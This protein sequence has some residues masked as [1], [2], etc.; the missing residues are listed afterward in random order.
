MWAR[1]ASPITLRDPSPGRRAATLSRRG[2][3]FV[4]ESHEHLRF[5]HPL[6]GDLAP[7]G[8][9]GAGHPGLLPSPEPTATLGGAVSRLVDLHALRRARGGG[10]GGGPGRRRE[11]RERGGGAGDQ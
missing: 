11:G 4:A 9:V 8:E 2:R 10:G 6:A 7:G 1:T 5:D 3:G